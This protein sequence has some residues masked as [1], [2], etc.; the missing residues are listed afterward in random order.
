MGNRTAKSMFPQI[1]SPHKQFILTHFF[2]GNIDISGIAVS[3]EDVFFSGFFQ[4]MF[5]DFC[6]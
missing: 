6:L 5:E 1:R 3:Q 2:G 4:S